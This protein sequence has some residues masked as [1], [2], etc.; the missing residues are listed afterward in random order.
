MSQVIALNIV[1][2]GKL[3]EIRNYLDTVNDRGLFLYVPK[4]AA[5][6]IEI[7]AERRDC[8]NN[9]PTIRLFSV[10]G[11]Y[12]YGFDVM[13]DSGSRVELEIRNDDETIYHLVDGVAGEPRQAEAAEKVETIKPI[14]DVTKLSSDD[15]FTVVSTYDDIHLAAK[16]ELN[17]RIENVKEKLV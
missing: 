16:A 11:T 5:Q 12:G 15:L 14:P 3:A 4:E 8:I 9:F 10:C 13:D 2:S 6:E 17:K 1:F 7:I